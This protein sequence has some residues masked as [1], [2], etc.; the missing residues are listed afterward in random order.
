MTSDFLRLLLQGWRRPA[1]SLAEAP[2]WERLADELPLLAA[3]THE[4]LERAGALAGELLARKRVTGAAGLELD[5][6]MQ[7]A[8]AADAVVPVLNLGLDW[9][10]GWAQIIV[11]PDEFVTEQEVED[12]IGVV[13]VGTEVRSGESW[14]AGPLVLSWADVAASDREAVWGHVVVHEVAH[15]LDMLHEGPNGF[16]PLHPGM[17][18]R[19]W[20]AVWTRAYE[21]LCAQVDAGEEPRID[22]YGAENPGE[23]FA[24][25]S[26]AFFVH[27][28]DLEA[29]DA[30][31][32]D[33]L[34]QFYRQDPRQ[35]YQ[36]P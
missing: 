22:P 27:P 36:A 17:D 25:A 31:L 5:E 34:A 30:E 2:L 29:M 6:A 9:Y 11:Y 1:P 32:Y 4:E 18:P 28:Y 7:I 16:P 13:H 3:L 20:T 19:R 24:V 10:A 33:L 35:R 12:E 8:I 23:F 15:K 21:A 26:E 14:D